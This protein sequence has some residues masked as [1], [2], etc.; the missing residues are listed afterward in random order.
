MEVINHQLLHHHCH[1]TI[2]TNI[3]NIMDMVMVMVTA[4]LPPNKDI[5]FRLHRK[6]RSQDIR[7]GMVGSDQEQN[8]NV[9]L[10]VHLWA[11]DQVQDVP[12]VKEIVLPPIKLR[13]KSL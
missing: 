11:A 3:N 7:V 10:E 4:S 1:H 9:M 5:H 2:N 6:L 12:L 13:R 8:M